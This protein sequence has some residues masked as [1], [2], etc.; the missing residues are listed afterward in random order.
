[1]DTT[2]E[3]AAASPADGTPI[4]RELRVRL[5]KPAVK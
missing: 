1:M 3:L 5:V 2:F 4:L